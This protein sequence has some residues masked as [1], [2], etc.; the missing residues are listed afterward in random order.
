MTIAD[1]A[2]AGTGPAVTAVRGP[3][4][5]FLDDPFRTGSAEAFRY[6]PDA[7]LLC[8]D[9]RITAAGEY[10]AL[11]HRLPPGVTPDHYPDHVIV[12]GFVDTHVHGVQTDVM[13]AFGADLTSW[14]EERAFPEEERFADDRYARAAAAVFCDQLLRHGTTTALVFGS[15]HP[16]S[17]DAL[18]EAA[19]RRD[20]RIACGKVLMDRNAPDA[21]R[22]T[23]QRGYEESRAL[24]DRWHGKGRAQYAVT[25][26]FAPSSTPEQLEAAAALWREHPGTLLHTHVS[27]TPDEV[28]WA[29]SLFPERAGY[30]DVYDHYGLLGPGAVLAHGVHLSPAERDRCA[31]TGTALAHC[32]G[33][34][35]ALGSGL[36]PLRETAGGPRPVTTGLGTDVGAGPTFSMLSTLYAAYQVAAVCG[37]PVDI[38]QAYY[39]ATRGGA[40][41]LGLADT[42]GSLVPGQ[43]AD[44]AVLD[45]RATPLLARRAA[46]AEDIEELLF[47]LAALGDDRT[48]RATYAA[49]RLVHDRDAAPAGGNGAA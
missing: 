14:L 38:V 8:A 12:P 33:S 39:L 37:A 5:R 17:A 3:L 16:G 25:P 28:A 30:L 4:V 2:G 29:R 15:V 7:L 27:E 32:P 6:T 26:R 19:A 20:L 18:F 34:N 31:A 1:D 10:A 35:L 43:E 47:V 22:D 21:L 11:R 36:F 9:G 42:V 40:A 13:A 46:R 41:A 44:F 48:V 49:G 23:A 45:P 24:L